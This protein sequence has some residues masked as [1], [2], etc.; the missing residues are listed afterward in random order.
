MTDRM[1]D[2]I[3][4]SL[5]AGAAG[6]ALG[7]GG[8]ISANTRMTI[9][10]AVGLLRG[11]VRLKQRGFGGPSP[12]T[13]Y[14]AYKEWY[15]SEKDSADEVCRSV[16]ES[17][18][19]GSVFEPINDSRGCGG[20]VRAAPVGLFAAHLP[21]HSIV[22]LAAESAAITHGHPLAYMPAAVLA[23]LVRFGL[24]TDGLSVRDCA[25][26]VMSAV[27]ETFGR[28]E[29]WP[30]FEQL[31]ARAMVLA[32]NEGAPAKLGSGEFADEALALALYCVLRHEADA[33]PIMNTLNA[34]AAH[35]AAVASL[36]GNIIGAYHGLAAVPEALID[37]LEMRDTLLEVGAD[38][39]S[40]W[41]DSRDQRP[42]PR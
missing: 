10:T 33:N 13:L 4:G 38:L 9:V 29:Y 36:A 27:K 1:L 16:M 21:T 3:Q 20:V 15:A 34:A 37:G 12:R 39:Y 35:G 8:M 5:L 17:G 24:Y 41:Q 23:E 26:M 7:N 25:P 2:K 14:Q 32:R 40:G 11:D 19:Y 31:I 42:E 22:M 30:A 18:N 28:N 6:D